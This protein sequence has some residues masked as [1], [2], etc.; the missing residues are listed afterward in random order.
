MSKAVQA[1]DHA[2]IKLNVFAQQHLKSSKIVV[3]A[4]TFRLGCTHHLHHARPSASSNVI[5]RDGMHKSL[6]FLSDV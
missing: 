2:P 6:P 4:S 3:V 5:I 1:I